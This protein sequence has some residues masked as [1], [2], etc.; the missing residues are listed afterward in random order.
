MY[1]PN[2]AVSAGMLDEVVSADAVVQTAQQRAQACAQLDR[3]AQCADRRQRGVHT[4]KFAS[5]G[6]TTSPPVLSRP[7]PAVNTPAAI[8]PP[9]RLSPS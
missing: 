3:E 8:A 7:R 4:T 1:S 6:I 9:R 5:F 2:D